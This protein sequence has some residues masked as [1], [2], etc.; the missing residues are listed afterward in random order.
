MLGNRPI[1]EAVFAEELDP[2]L[3]SKVI[4]CHVHVSLSEHRSAVS[5]ERMSI[6]WAREVSSEQSWEQMRQTWN[7]LFPG[8]EVRA[9]AFGVP[10]REV[11]LIANNDYI[12]RGV[13]DPANMA[14]GL[15]LTRPDWEPAAIED[16]MRAGF[17]GIKPYPDLAPESIDEPGIFDFVP[18]AQLEVVNRL[19][20]ILMLHLPR[21]D[22]LADADNIRDLLEISDSFPSIRLILAH[23]GRSFCLPTAQRGLPS[24]ARRS[25]VYFDT[26]A[27]LNADVFAYAIEVVGPDRILYGSDLPITLMR[28]F[29][30]HVGETYINYTD[31]PYSWNVNRKSPAEEARY[32]YYLYEELRALIDAAKRSGVGKAALEKVLYSNAAKLLGGPA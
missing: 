18:R 26:A 8:R 12:L 17:L 27:N 9:L 11:D 32:T 31:G 5:P 23:V 15:L 1:D 10:F 14:S 19:G 21:K 30:G 20:G 4:D 3:P 22:R 28:G 2:W 7:A 24:F 29:R 6:N 16:A 25:N 13:R